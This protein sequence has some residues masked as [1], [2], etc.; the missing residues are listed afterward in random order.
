[1]STGRALDHIGLISN[2]LDGLVARYEGMGF[3]LTPR[4]YHPDHMGTSNQ[5]VQFTGRNFIELIEVDRPDGILPPKPGHVGFGHFAKEMLQRREGMCLVVFRTQDRDADLAAW[6]ARGLDTYAPFEFER[7]ATMPDGSQVTVRFELGF[8]TSEAVP[9]TIFFVCHNQMEELFW[10]PEFQSHANGAEEITAV[11]LS[12]ADPA[13]A[14]EF[15]SALFDGEISDR[16]GGHS[17][18]CGPHR[19]DVSSPDALQGA[20]KTGRPPFGSIGFEVRCPG[21]AGT[22][23]AATEAGGAFIDWGK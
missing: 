9:D 2:D 11:S 8:V 16:A 13:K 4:A 5:L 7:L 6:N 17:V 20:W 14:A 15:L 18:S 3:T 19:I 10:K 21:R 23:T 12:A 1:M 22:S